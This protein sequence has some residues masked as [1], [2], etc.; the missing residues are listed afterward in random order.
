MDSFTIFFKHEPE[1]I[2]SRIRSQ[3][4]HAGESAVIRL[5]FDKQKAYEIC[6][7]QIYVLELER[8]P[9]YS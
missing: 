6:K 7:K 3:E 9:T 5:L 4:S 8:N 1:E 2:T